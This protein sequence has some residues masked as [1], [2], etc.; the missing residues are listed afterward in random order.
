MYSTPMPIKIVG[1][2]DAEGNVHP[3]AERDTPSVPDI[4][5]KFLRYGERNTHC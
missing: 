4:Y 5:S 3:V 1:T 2:V